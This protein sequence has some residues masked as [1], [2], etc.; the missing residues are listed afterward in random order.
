MFSNT[1]WYRWIA[2]YN[3]SCT[4]KEDYLMW[5]Y[6]GDGVVNGITGSVDLNYFYGSEWN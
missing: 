4:Y 2:Q 5:Q 6:T 1:S 3:I